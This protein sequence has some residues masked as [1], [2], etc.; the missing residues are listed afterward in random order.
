VHNTI[1]KVKDCHYH[2]LVSYGR[3][4]TLTSDLMTLKWN[5]DLGVM[6]ES[7]IQNLTVNSFPFQL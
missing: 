5:C 6:R 3:L 2:S 7:G 4:V 1:V